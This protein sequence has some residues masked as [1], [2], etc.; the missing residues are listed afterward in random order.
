MKWSTEAWREIR[1]QWLIESEMTLFNEIVSMKKSDWWK[2]ESNQSEEMKKAEGEKYREG[3]TWRNE[4]EKPMTSMKVKSEKWLKEAMKWRM[5]E[6]KICV[7]LRN[8]NE[9]EEMKKQKSGNIQLNDQWNI[10]TERKKS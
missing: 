1:N 4:E 5:R 8:D 3:N 9:N 6:M 2:S 10:E 7:K